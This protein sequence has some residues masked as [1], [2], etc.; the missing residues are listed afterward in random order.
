MQ[1]WVSKYQDEMPSRERQGSEPVTEEREN[2]WEEGVQGT[3]RPALDREARIEA[4]MSHFSAVRVPFRVERGLVRRRTLET[5]LS[6]SR[7]PPRQPNYTRSNGI[8][9]DRD[10]GI[11]AEVS[12]ERAKRWPPQDIDT[13]STLTIKG[14]VARNLEARGH[15]R[16]AAA[17]KAREDRESQAPRW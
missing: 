8:S 1:Y 13:R 11:S 7:S 10:R 17:V 14:P 4:A 15:A 2:D 16:L 3:A 12:I 6:S 9:E 5:N